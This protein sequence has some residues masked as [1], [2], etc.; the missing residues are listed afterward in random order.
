[1]ANEEII[2]SPIFIN[3]IKLS[4]Q[5]LQQSHKDRNMLISDFTCKGFFKM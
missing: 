2:Y 5:V 4:D 1:M 3:V